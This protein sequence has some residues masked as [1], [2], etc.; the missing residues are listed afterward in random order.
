MDE[1]EEEEKQRGGQVRRGGVVCR[2]KREGVGRVAMSGGGGVTTDTASE[3]AIGR[4]D[5]LEMTWKKIR[6]GA[7][8]TLLSS[9]PEARRAE[10]EGSAGKGVFHR[11]MLRSQHASSTTTCPDRMETAS[12]RTGALVSLQPL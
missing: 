1:E 4:G 12:P 5:L 8:K 9:S 10:K 7:N 2:R 6:N 3:P 11:H